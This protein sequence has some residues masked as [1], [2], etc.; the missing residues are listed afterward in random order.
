MTDNDLS[1]KIMKVREEQEKEKRVIREAIED[2]MSRQSGRIFLGWLL[3]ATGVF[4]DPA[5]NES[6]EKFVGRRSVGIMLLSACNEIDPT[7]YLKTIKGE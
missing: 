1:K 2:V 4:G 6:L 3:D 5:E 7:I